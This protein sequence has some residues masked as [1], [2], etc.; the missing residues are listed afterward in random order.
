MKERCVS[1]S[2]VSIFFTWPFNALDSDRVIQ[3]KDR[4]R[5]INSMG[6]R[7]WEREGRVR[8]VCRLQAAGTAIISISVLQTV[9][10]NRNK[11]AAVIRFIGF[12]FGCSEPALYS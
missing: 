11:V 1:L 10:K 6:V 8:R 9:M 2:G 12:D 5:V 3:K 4:G 7:A